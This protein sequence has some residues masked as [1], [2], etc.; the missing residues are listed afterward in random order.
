MTFVAPHWT[1]DLLK[2]GHEIPAWLSALSSTLTC[3][4][5]RQTRF[6]EGSVKPRPLSPLQACGLPFLHCNLRLPTLQLQPDETFWLGST[7][8]WQNRVHREVLVR[9]RTVLVHMSSNLPH[10]CMCKCRTEDVD[11]KCQFNYSEWVS[12]CLHANAPQCICCIHLLEEGF[13]QKRAYMANMCYNYNLVP[14]C[15]YIVIKK[16]V[17]ALKWVVF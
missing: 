6:L 13:N 15:T 5:V 7:E 9:D 10:C 11:K 3:V 1:V 2:P 16:Q 12:R 14:I 8:V 17:P 4:C